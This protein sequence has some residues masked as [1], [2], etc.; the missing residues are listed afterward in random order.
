LGHGKKGTILKAENRKWKSG[1]GNNGA[2]DFR[3][4]IFMPRFWLFSGDGRQN[5]ARGLL[6][7]KQRQLVGFGRKTCAG[8]V[9]A[10]AHERSLIPKRS[11]ICYRIGSPKT[12]EH[13]SGNDPGTVSRLARRLQ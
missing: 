3:I 10:K 7:D 1:P 11:P 13:F 9:P 4:P 12:S 2:M 6:Q 8:L 5:S